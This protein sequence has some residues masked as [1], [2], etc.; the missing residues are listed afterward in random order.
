VSSIYQNKSRN[1]I[2]ILVA[3]VVIGGLSL[4]YTQQLVD[5]LAQRERRQIDLYAKVLQFISDP[6]VEDSR[7]LSFLIEEVIQENQNSSIPV[8]IVD[9]EGNFLSHI[10]IEIAENATANQIN[11]ILSKELEVM[12]KEYEPIEILI[13]PGYKQYIYYRNSYLIKQLKYY[14]VLQLV[15]ISIFVFFSY[16]AFSFSRKAEQNRVWVGLSKETAHQLGTPLSSLM[17]WVEYFK[18]DDRYKEESAILEIEKDIQRLEMVTARFSNIGSAPVMKQEDLG[19]VIAETMDYLRKRISPKVSMNLENDFVEPVVISL[20]KPL[21]GWVIEN[22]CKNAVDSM[23]GVGSLKVHL[24]KNPSEQIVI[25]ITDSGKGI[26]KNHF[27]KVFEPGFSTKQRGWGLGL[28]LTKRIVEVY[29]KG[30]IFVK[31]SEAGKGTT[32]RILLNI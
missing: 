25:D 5:V 3:A 13:P 11:E 2:V 30:K 6:E 12:K 22:I 20:N 16:L 23:G 26:P 19:A 15:V 14:P 28:T 27:K 32:F 4:Y 9:E 18:A 10:N 7:S 21:F 1:K 24:F 31:A 8:I 29:H 17:A